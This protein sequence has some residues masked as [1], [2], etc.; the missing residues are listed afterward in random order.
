M[1]SVYNTNLLKI[2]KLI[3]HLDIRSIHK[4]V[5]VIT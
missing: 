4:F 3:I 5:D 2:E 1:S